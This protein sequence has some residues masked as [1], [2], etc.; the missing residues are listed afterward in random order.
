MF[1]PPSRVHSARMART[2]AL[3]A[4]RLTRPLANS[5]LID[6]ADAVP[7]SAS[8][9]PSERLST[10]DFMGLPIQYIGR[11]SRRHTLYHFFLELPD[12][13]DDRPDDVV[14]VQLRLITDEL[15]QLRNIGHSP[16]H[17]L[18]AGFI[19]LV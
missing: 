10:R 3:S 4:F 11:F 12:V 19:R 5:S 9:R 7:A 16:R 15:P 6:W 14:E 17:V 18:E 8:N 2:D 13:L 1:V